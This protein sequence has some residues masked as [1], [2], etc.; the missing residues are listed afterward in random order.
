MGSYAKAAAG[1]EKPAKHKAKDTV[2]AIGRAFQAVSAVLPGWLQSSTVAGQLAAAGY[3]TDT[4]V[5]LLQSACTAQQH[6]AQA[7]PD[8][9][10]QLLQGLGLA[11]SSMPVGLACNN[12]L[13]T[14]LTGLSEQQLVVGSS[15]RCSGCRVARYCCKNC[16]VLQWKSGHKPACKAA[17]AT[18]S[19]QGS[20]SLSW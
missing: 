11:L 4:V 17:A 8:V 2:A 20:C 7:G 12:P 1:P 19:C 15:R 3:V 13:C 18:R 9:L 10:A 14:T 16:Q 5:E 6:V